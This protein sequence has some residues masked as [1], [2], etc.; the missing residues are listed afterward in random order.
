MIS[1]GYLGIRSIILKK[2]KS[3][4]ILVNDRN[5]SPSKPKTTG[6]MNI[7]I[8]D[9]ENTISV[10]KA[11]E[12]EIEAD[13][14]GKNI[15]GYDFIIKYDSQA[16]NLVKAESAIANF[17]I[18]TFENEDGGITITGLKDVEDN[19]ETVLSETVLVSLSLLSKMEGDYDI[20]LV[21]KREKEITQMV[22]DKTAVLYPEVNSINVIAE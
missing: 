6:A 16:F 18:F 10:G 14:E 2:S 20:T 13:S 15:V 8:P 22:D 12:L 11:F 4:L 5:P 21:S 19:S 17:K 1:Y 9:G 3:P 7:K